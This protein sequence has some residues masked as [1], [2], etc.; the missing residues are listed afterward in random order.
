MIGFK[1][2]TRR[3]TTIDHKINGHFLRTSLMVVFRLSYVVPSGLF[4]FCT[5][6]HTHEQVA[7]H[8]VKDT[9]DNYVFINSQSGS[10]NILSE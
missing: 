3:C 8:A 1:T 2:P 5:R 7:A 9:P 6:E 4:S 10:K